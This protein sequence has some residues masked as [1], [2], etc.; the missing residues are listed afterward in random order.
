FARHVL[1]SDEPNSTEFDSQ[2]EHPV[3]SLMPDQHA[4]EDMG[5]TMRLGSYPCH[6][7]G[8]SKAAAAYDAELVQERHRHRWEFNNSYRDKL[9]D[10]GMVFSGLSPDGRLVEIAEL[11]HHPFMLGS[12]FHPEFK[13]R[14]NRP[15]PLFAAFLGAAVARQESRQASANG[16]LPIEEVASR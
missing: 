3:I 5:G 4:L 1:H 9:E 6:L 10:A 13:S 16:V 11:K 12:Q 7:K 8:G 15:H 14:P 2:T